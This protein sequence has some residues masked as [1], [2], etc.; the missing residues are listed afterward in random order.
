MKNVLTFWD[1]GS[2][3]NRPNGRN[4]LSA[5]ARFASACLYVVQNCSP[6]PLSNAPTLSKA[7]EGWHARVAHTKTQARE[8]H[9]FAKRTQ[10]SLQASLNQKDMR[11]SNL[12]IKAIQTYSSL[13]RDITRNPVRPNP[14]TR[15]TSVTSNCIYL[16]LFSGK[17]DCLFL[18][19]TRIARM[20]AKRGPWLLPTYSGPPPPTPTARPFC[21]FCPKLCA[22]CVSVAKP[23]QIPANAGQK[24]KSTVDLDCEGTAVRDPVERD[25]RTRP[26]FVVF[27]PFA[28]HIRNSCNSCQHPQPVINALQAVSSG[29]KTPGGLYLMNRSF[30]NIHEGNCEKMTRIYLCI[31]PKL[32]I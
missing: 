23:N 18:C 5:L 16:R 19:F 21:R 3:R 22:L 32:T 27:V 4:V 12:P 24:M 26:A 8:K 14:P 9:D 30:C 7:P 25:K 15:V 11:S 10:F 28:R 6:L 31:R 20:D 17:K 2:S 13:R 1:D 29:F